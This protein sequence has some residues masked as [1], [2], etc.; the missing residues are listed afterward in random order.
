MTNKQ[1]LQD[2][3]QNLVSNSLKAI[4][5]N[6]LKKIKCTGTLEDSSFV[7][8]F[9]DNGYGIQPGDEAWIFGLY[10]TR[11]AEH[12]GAGLGLY[13][14]EKQIKSLNGKIEVVESEFKPQGATFK[15]TLPFNQVAND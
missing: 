11:T 3:F 10:N 9:S 13:I 4:K 1:A 6:D 8:Y 14:V 12:G 2:V 5:N 7:L 15:I